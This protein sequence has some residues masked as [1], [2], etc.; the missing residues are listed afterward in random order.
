MA[1]VYA[2]CFNLFKA[3]PN[4]NVTYPLKPHQKVAIMRNIEK[5]LLEVLRDPKEIPHL[6]RTMVL[7]RFT[8]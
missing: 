2:K 4:V 8:E 3:G 5:M 6:L 7:G 1:T